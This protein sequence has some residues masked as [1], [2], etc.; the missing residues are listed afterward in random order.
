MITLNRAP[1]DNIKR[2]STVP[3][4]DSDGVEFRSE[5]VSISIG[6]SVEFVVVLV[7]G[8]N[9]LTSSVV[10]IR[11]QLGLNIRTENYIKIDNVINKFRGYIQMK[12]I[13]P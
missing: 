2:L 5:S 11:V 4:S 6:V 7:A 8:S 9:L 3:A 1:S 13:Y 12:N 10:R